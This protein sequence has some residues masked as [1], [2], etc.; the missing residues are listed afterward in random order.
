MNDERNVAEKFDPARGE[1]VQDRAVFKGGGRADENARD[2][3]EHEGS[4]GKRHRPAETVQNVDEPGIIVQER[5]FVKYR[6]INR[7]HT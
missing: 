4:G 5:R 1:G 2:E 3:R 7:K 6:P